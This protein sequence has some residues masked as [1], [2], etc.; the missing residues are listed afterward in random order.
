MEDVMNPQVLYGFLFGCSHVCF[1]GC[2]SNEPTETLMGMEEGSTG[3]FNV[4][5]DHAGTER[6]TLLYVPE[7]YDET[8]SH[9]LILNFH[10]FGGTSAEQLDWA[11]MRPLA[12][13]DGVVLLYPQ[14]TLLEGNS[15][16]NAEDLGGD[17]KSETDDIGFVLELIAQLEGRYNI[18]SNRVYIMG[19]SNGSFFSYYL[20]CSASEYFAGVAS[21]SGTMLDDS[22]TPTHPMPMINLHG[23]QDSVVAYDGASVYPGVDSVMSFWVGFNQTE[24]EP[25]LE[26]LMDGSRA[27]EHYVYAAGEVGV[28][29]EHYKVVGGQHVWFDMTLSNQDTGELIWSYLSPYSLDSLIQQ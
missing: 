6:T 21:V 2:S 7:S 17:N 29:V 1:A 25:T 19:Y 10:G 12:E 5:I 28:A 18:D 3:L 13:R 26:T 23:T 20:A 11:D 16:W 22:C 15:H 9:P 24:T 14:G 27:V 8:V 4:G